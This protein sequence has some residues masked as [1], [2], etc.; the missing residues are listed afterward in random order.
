MAASLPFFFRMAPE[1]ECTVLNQRAP[2]EEYMV[3]HRLSF[4]LGIMS[5]EI[6][7][8]FLL[9]LPDNSLNFSCRTLVNAHSCTRAKSVGLQIPKPP[10]FQRIFVYLTLSYTITK[11]GLCLQCIERA[12]R[13]MIFCFSPLTKLNPQ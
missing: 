9:Q 1:G 6:V 4:L 10:N 2:V 11:A 8:K 5:C 13:T 3:L 12:S 7:Q